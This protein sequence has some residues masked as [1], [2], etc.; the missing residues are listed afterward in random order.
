[1]GN[2]ENF[3]SLFFLFLTGLFLISCGA[4]PNNSSE[5]LSGDSYFRESG[6]DFSYIK[7]HNELHRTIYPR[8]IAY[9]YNKDFILAAQVP[10]LE[11]DKSLKASELNSGNENFE[12]LLKKADSILAND[13][14]YIKVL[15]GKINFWIIKNNTHELIG[16]LTSSQYLTKREELNIPNELKLDLKFSH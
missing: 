3:K 5:E 9:A 8:V 4:G 7:S 10:N 12:G 13:P 6:H 1:M 16:P 15:S 2:I 14:Y 11:H